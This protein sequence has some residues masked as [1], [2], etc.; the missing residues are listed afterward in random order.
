[1]DGD[2]LAGNVT[3]ES[4]VTGVEEI[5][6]ETGADILTDTTFVDGVA[7]HRLNIPMALTVTDLNNLMKVVFGDF[8]EALVT[9]D[10]QVVLFCGNPTVGAIHAGEHSIGLAIDGSGK[11]RPADQF[12]DTQVGGGFDSVVFHYGTIYARN[13]ELSNEFLNKTI[14]VPPSRLSR[15]PALGAEEML[16]RLPILDGILTIGQTDLRS[17]QLGSIL[18]NAAE[19]LDAGNLL[20]G[21]N[22]LDGLDNLVV[23]GIP[24]VHDVDDDAGSQSG[25]EVRFND[26]LGFCVGNGDSHKIICFG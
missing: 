24:A 16:E 12:S 11:S 8:H 18:H 6:T 20:V 23:D 19:S 1:M 13:S 10:E 3:G 15:K 7:N 4:A 2:G 9:E 14:G 25:G 26:G 22:S 5:S 21:G 17:V